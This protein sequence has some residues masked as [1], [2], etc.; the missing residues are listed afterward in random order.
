MNEEAKGKSQCNL[1]GIKPSP[2]HSVLAYSLDVTGYETYTIYFKD[3]ATGKLLKD[4]IPG[5]MCV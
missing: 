2:D 1:G 4:V 3:I 5:A